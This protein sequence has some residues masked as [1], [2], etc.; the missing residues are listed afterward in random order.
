MIHHFL[1]E[2]NKY[3]EKENKVSDNVEKESE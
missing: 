3:R 1:A 2:F